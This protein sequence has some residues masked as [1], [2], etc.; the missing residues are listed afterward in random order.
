VTPGFSERTFEFCFNSEYCQLNA[1]LLATYPNIP[2]QRM[3]KDLGYDVEFEI[4][5]GT[6]TR[7]LFLQHKISSFAEKRAGLNA[8]F[9]AAHDG[10]YF[11]FPVD[12]DQHNTLCE[13]S[14]TRGN[15]FY[16]APR[17]CLR[18]ELE[19]HYRATSIGAN[20]ILL[21]PVDVGDI[22]DDNRHNI[23]Y[24]PSGE[25]PTLHSEP[26]HFRRSF[27]GGKEDAPELRRVTINSEYIRQLS[28][29]LLHR[30]QRSRFAKF[31]TPTIQRDR[32]VKQAQILLAHVFQV[33]WLLLP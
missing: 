32:P 2:S 10:P 15:A 11:R 28:D 16:C 31:L 6:F 12:N 8:Q 7:S 4:N 14:R 30:A 25:T 26:I 18:R 21:D 9:Y 20:S 24:N 3:E 23:T 5:N 22:D 1:A 29:E 19:T 27:S 33:S 13:L 17:F